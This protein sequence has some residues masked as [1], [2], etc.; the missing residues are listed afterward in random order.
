MDYTKK[1][2]K[3]YKFIIVKDKQIGITLMMDLTLN[4]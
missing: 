4:S 2:I 3:K 1:S